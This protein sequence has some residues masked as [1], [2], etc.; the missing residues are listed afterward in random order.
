MNEIHADLLLYYSLSYSVFFLLLIFSSVLF[1]VLPSLNSF[2][3]FLINFSTIL[4]FITV[5]L[6][7]LGD[8]SC[9]SFYSVMFCPWC[10]CW[11]LH[12]WCNNTY[13]VV[14]SVLCWCL[15]VG[16]PFCWDR[17][18]VLIEMLYC[19]ASAWS[20]SA[21]YHTMKS[22]WGWLLWLKGLIISPLICWTWWAASPLVT[23]CAAEWL[24][25][26]SDSCWTNW[27]E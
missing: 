4:G 2:L 21:A 11:T 18:M 17:L 16:L 6:R 26:V 19:Y 9:L 13:D 20:V 27:L 22:F 25:V 5:S 24:L 15:C 12:C 10:S 14:L 23:G 8:A 3:H 7:M 1:S